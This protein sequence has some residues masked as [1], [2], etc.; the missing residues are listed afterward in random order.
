M[1]TISLIVA[2]SVLA[3]GLYAQADQPV[4]KRTLKANRTLVYNDVP[5]QVDNLSDFL[6]ESQWYGRLRLNTFRWDWSQEIPGKRQDNWAVGLG[7]S[8]MVKT[9][10]LYGFG[11]TIDAYTS[12]NPWHMDK[13]DIKF[14]KAGKDTLS[15]HDV[16]D[17]DRFY[18]NVIAQ[19]YIE[20]K[21]SKTSVKYGRQKFESF[22]TK[23][24]DTKMIPNT[25]EGVTVSSKDLPKH[26]IKLAWF[27]KQKLRDHT[28]FHDPLTYGDRSFVGLS[29]EEKVL[30]AWSNNDDSAMHRGLSYDN[31]R[32]AGQSTDHDLLIAEVWSMAVPHL[33]AMLNYTA[34]PDVLSSATAEA[35]Y[36][37]KAGDYK[38][39]PGV[40]YM[41][42]FDNGG[43]RVGGATLIGALSPYY[44]G[45]VGHADGGYDDPHSLD[46]WLVAARIDLRSPGAWK[47]R[48]G[49]SHI[50]DEA[51]IVAP[52]RGFPTGGFTR[53]M[54]QYNWQA[55]TDTWMLRGDYDFGKAGWVSGLSAMFRYAIEDFDESKYVDL[56]SK[57][58]YLTPTDRHALELG[59]IWKVP[60]IRGLEARVRMGFVDADD[61][62]D[63][64]E[65]SYNEYRFEMN[66]LF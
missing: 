5:P 41:A 20:Y 61:S 36:T 18:M 30:A 45:V 17:K 29:P 46:G 23:S 11:A 59:L 10:Y 48:L 38:I 57:R 8:L 39:I 2:A 19:L 28:E 44:T 43:G 50:G 53:A 52:W 1:R 40:R 25:F 14:L 65:N 7:G 42:Q 56:A 60:Q 3:V 55:N 35:H 62:P 47:L 54:G 9:A 16:Y 33:K 26:R 24:N 12:Q 27:T 37:F 58:L 51:D 6:R 15:R 31:Y 34:G 32:R 21:R 49:Y 4:E 66:Y 63:G 64:R 22:L 13:E